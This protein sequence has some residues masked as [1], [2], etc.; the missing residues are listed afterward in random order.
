MKNKRAPLL[1]AGLAVFAACAVPK[2]KVS[3]SQLVQQHYTN[4]QA[5]APKAGAMAPEAACLHI[6]EGYYPYCSK[7]RP[8][9][10]ILEGTLALDNHCE[11]TAIDGFQR[12]SLMDVMRH[13]NGAEQVENV[14]FVSFS[15]IERH[16][17][18]QPVRALVRGAA[19]DNDT[20]QIRG[21]VTLYSGVY[22]NDSTIFFTRRFI[23]TTPPRINFFSREGRLKKETRVALR[24][25]VSKTD[26]DGPHKAY[27]KRMV[28]Y[29]RNELSDSKPLVFSLS[30]VFSIDSLALPY[31]LSECVH[32]R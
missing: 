23:Y 3:Y 12:F 24:L 32:G 9:E 8:A 17:P 10:K 2:I 26:G 30:D 27:L 15:Q 18:T 20:L 25:I 5:S 16:I 7:L 4:T 13:E 1:L 11:D 29:G 19:A 14:L 21:A 28:N 6:Y 31:F 22:E